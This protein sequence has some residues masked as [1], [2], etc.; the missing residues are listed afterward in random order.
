MLS[1]LSLT[2]RLQ[3]QNR[4]SILP[5]L[6]CGLMVLLAALACD[7]EN[8]SKETT[9]SSKSIELLSG[10]VAIDNY[11]L[12]VDKASDRAFILNALASNLKEGLTV[13]NLEPNTFYMEARKGTA[14][15]ALALSSGLRGVAKPTALTLLSVK[16]GSRKRYDIGDP[17]DSL[18]QS[19]NGKYAVLYFGQGSSELLYNRNQIAVVTLPSKAISN[20]GGAASEPTVATS[21][22]MATLNVPT[23][24]GEPTQV[25]LSPALTFGR[26]ERM[27]AV[28]LS[29]A[30]ATLVDITDLTRLY[31]QVQLSG[32]N[33]PNPVLPEQVL[34]NAARREIYI[35]GTNSKD[36]FVLTL[37][38]SRFVENDFATSVGQVTVGDG[39]SDMAIYGEEEAGQLLAV[40]AGNSEVSVIQL[41]ALDSTT[42][43]QTT[44]IALEHRAD[45]VIAFYG[46]SPANLDAEEDRAL[47]YEIGGTELTF[48]NLYDVENLKEQ[49]LETLTVSEPISKV[50]PIRTQKVAVLLHESSRVDLLDLQTRKISVVDVNGTVDSAVYHTDL[51]VPRLWIAQKNQNILGYMD[52]ATGKTSEILLDQP[53]SQLVMMPSTA[54]PK[55]SKLVPI[56]EKD[57]K[58]TVT[59]INLEKVPTRGGTFTDFPTVPADASE[60][61]NAD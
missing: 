24:G 1:P 32:E 5:S 59:V 12:M 14:K 26:R 31:T 61:A 33:N 47:L 8:D 18:L 9:T 54:Y 19:E 49:N 57:G 10:S 11:L 34:F 56:Q 39:A 44:R 41:P 40:S 58:V 29:R 28:I 48:L 37:T 25:A 60:N 6:I 17:F 16:N 53:L 15:E 13:V 55:K 45:R 30:Y 21:K 46:S 22:E 20:S 23:P 51:P 27:L 43:P 4:K 38:D 7:D 52:L 50:I 42:Y 35:R 2:L 36:L 3:N